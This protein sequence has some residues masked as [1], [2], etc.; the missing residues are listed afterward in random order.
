[1]HIIFYLT[2]GLILNRWHWKDNLSFHLVFKF[3]L[4]P[5]MKIFPFVVKFLKHPQNSPF[6]IFFL[7]QHKNHIKQLATNQLYYVC[8][9]TT[10]DSA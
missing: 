5:S 1:M 4:N 10:L 6:S 2:I 9:E 3:K 7:H 8:K